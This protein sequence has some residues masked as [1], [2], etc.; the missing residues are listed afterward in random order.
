V[1]AG[2]NLLSCSGRGELDTAIDPTTTAASSAML[3][4]DAATDRS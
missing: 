2:W 4:L 3:R 1:L